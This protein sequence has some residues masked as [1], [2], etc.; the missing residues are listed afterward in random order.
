MPT[1]LAGRREWIGLAVIA[2]PCVVYAM[3]LTVL[4]LALPAIS[5]DLHP[6]SA[7]L[8]WIVDVYGFLV[9]GSLVTM[10]TLGDR[11]GR[12]R[13][14]MFGAA[15]FAGAS[16]VAA[17]ATSAPM[18]IVARAVLG[19]A[20]G[21]LAPSTLSLIRVMFRD[22]RQRTFAI[23]VWVTSYSAGAAIGPLAGGA[24]LEHAWWGSVFLLGVPVMA[25]LLVVGPRLLPEYRDP[26]A[27]RLDM[28]SAA[29]SLLAVLAVVFGLKRVA[30]QGFTPD[31]LAAVLAGAALGAAFARRQSRLA[32]P[33][34]E[35]R[36]FR[37]P[38]FSAALTTNL[39]GFFAVFGVSVFT[40]QYLQSVLGY[41][42]LAA[43]LWML[44]E[45]LG[46]IASSMVVP[47]LA[48]RFRVATLIVGGLVV[49]AAGLA[50]LAQVDRDLAPLVIGSVVFSLGIGAVATLATDVTVGAAPPE[51]AGAASAIS[52]TGSEL[53]GALGIAVLGSLLTAV[54][55]AGVPAGAPAAARDSVGG[56][57]TAGDPALLDTAR[58]AFTSALQVTAGAGAAV[59][60]TAAAI[61][62]LLL[63]ERPVR[64][65]AAVAAA[66][67]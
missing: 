35:L 12:R 42:P 40:A 23:G 11:I 56:A 31:A 53:G 46:F 60:L 61:A 41:A 33:L 24:L 63:R 37:I 50:V 13:L 32:H 51:R 4:N 59:L 55:R 45:A 34:I 30:S 1:T 28:R 58:E 17:F 49:G 64:A 15:G 20:G 25:L 29:L 38:A 26:A 10:G 22:D 44:P 27:G 52:E 43:G 36:L 67:C 62:A 2:L 65:P 6:G 5:A 3:D 47:G 7:Q 19:L 48:Q 14:L 39:L 21:T 54:Y 16:L 66:G 18:L 57:V 8:L 9:A